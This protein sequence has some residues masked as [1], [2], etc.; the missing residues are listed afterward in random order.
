[1][2]EKRG[3]IAQREQKG[4]RFEDKAGIGNLEREES[5]RGVN[6]SFKLSRRSLYGKG[7]K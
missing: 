3:Y 6:A 2:I 5:I 1:M 7:Y 4:S